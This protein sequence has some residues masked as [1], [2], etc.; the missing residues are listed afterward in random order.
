LYGV[1]LG[2]FIPIFGAIGPIQSAL[3]VELRE[4]LDIT[5][6]KTK[7][8]EYKIESEKDRSRISPEILAVGGSLSLFGF[9]VYYLLP[10]ALLSLDLRLFFLLFV[11]LLLGMLVGLVLLASNLQ[12]FVEYIVGNIF[13]FWATPVLRTLSLKNLIAH[14]KRN[15]KTSI[16]CVLL[17]ALLLLLSCRCR[18]TVRIS[19]DRDVLLPRVVLLRCMFSSLLSFHAPFTQVLFVVGLHHFHCCCCADGVPNVPVQ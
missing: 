13:L 16:M 17:R 2:L 12:G 15:W 19:S 6:S 10:L 3:K 14:R 7:V 11:A 18:L 8:I 5:R 4:A 9:L 1:V